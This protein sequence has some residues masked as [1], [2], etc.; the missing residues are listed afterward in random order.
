MLPS[1]RLAVKATKFLALP[2]ATNTLR[3]RRPS[4]HLPMSWSAS[5]EV[6]DWI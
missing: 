2:I 1:S 6:C 4:V 5:E 3:R